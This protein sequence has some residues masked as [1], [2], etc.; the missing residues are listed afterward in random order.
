MSLKGY[1]L[2]IDYEF[3][4]GCHSCEVACKNER[5]IPLGKW[6]IKVETIGP[7]KAEGDRYEFNHIP[8]PTSL[9]NLCEERIAKGKKPSCVHH[10]LCQVMDYGPIDE[11]AKKAAEKGSKVVMFLP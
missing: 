2:L 8:C 11:L 9:C 4:S 3:C 10:C 5:N 6:G 1:G 7:W